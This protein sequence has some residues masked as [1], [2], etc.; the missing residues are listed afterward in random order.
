MLS[1]YGT[2]AVVACTLGARCAATH[3]EL[4]ARRATAHLEA[5]VACTAG[6]AASGLVEMGRRSS[7]EEEDEQHEDEEKPKEGTKGQHRDRWLG[8]YY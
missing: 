7:R 8:T 2:A 3:R 1:P 6:A 5:V 4:T